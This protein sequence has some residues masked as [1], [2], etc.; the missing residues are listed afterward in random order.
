MNIIYAVISGNA[1]AGKSTILKYLSKNMKGIFQDQIEII[2]EK[3]LY[4]PL[5]TNVFKEP[6]IWAFPFQLYFPLQRFTR[7]LAAN[8]HYHGNKILLMERSLF[9][10]KLFYKY[11][12][13]KGCISAEMETTYTTLMDYFIKHTLKPNIIIHLRG[14]TEILLERV[15]FGRSTGERSISLSKEQLQEYISS[16][17]AL[18]N[19][20][21]VHASDIC[22]K[23]EE[24]HITQVDYDVTHIADH[25]VKLLNEYYA[26]NLLVR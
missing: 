1:G 8:Q 26:S 15:D 2:D 6:N 10:D 7:L 21:S 25:I 24:F 13:G 4:H 5:F 22:D 23:Y 14:V 3:E 11:Y 20:W 9:E 17:N 18:Y 12:R 19:E 16:L